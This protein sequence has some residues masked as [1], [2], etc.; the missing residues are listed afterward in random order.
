M[1]QEEKKVFELHPLTK[2]KRI[3]LF[4]GDYFITFI[5]SF[6]LFNIAVF[7]L[8][9]IIAKTE[10]RNNEATAL[11]ERADQ[12]L[13][14]SGII[15]EDPDGSQSFSGR[16]NYTFKVFLSY[17][18]FDEENPD[19]NHKDYGHKEKNEVIKNYYLTYLNDEQA[20][21]ND[22]K[23]VNTDGLFEIGDTVNSIKLKGEYKSL[24]GTE[25]LEVSDEDKYS[26]N[27]KNFRDHV[28]AQ[29]FY[30]HV[31]KNITDNDFVKDGVSYNDCV[32][33]AAN[34]NK[35]LQWV[36]V[37]CAYIS[38]VL[39]WGATYLLY[40]MI[41]SE[42]R[43]PTMS[44]MKANK[45]QTRS[46]MGINRVDVLGQS[47]YQLLLCMSSVLFMPVLF[48]GIAYCFNL[49][50][51]FIVTFISFVLALASL[52]VLIFNQFN[53]SG[54]DLLT[55]TVVVP[56]TELDNLYKEQNSDE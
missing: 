15:F 17:Y 50:T 28:F 47:F 18:A 40:P 6:I 7:P 36:P 2:W 12:L 49:P 44:V 21:L 51:L 54:S 55:F 20:Y 8:G 52:V 46:L 32:K 4:L 14:N 26:T 5:L 19:A 31:Y 27:M 34:I 48:F 10:Q 43:T 25:L 23:S 29:L 1:E 41:N 53:K 13:I 45:L 56:V 3:L 42:R 39:S 11:S 35:S 30:I 38:I 24:L 9:K 16:A 33:K 22:F 37:I